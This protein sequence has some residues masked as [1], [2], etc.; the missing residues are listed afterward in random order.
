MIPHIRPKEFQ[1]DFDSFSNHPSFADID[2]RERGKG[3]AIRCERLLDLNDVSLTTIQVC[4]ILGAIGVVDGKP[5][6]E[7]IYYSIACRIAQL[8]NLPNCYAANRV[9]QEVHTRGSC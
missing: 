5:A 2:P 9:E 6:S 7:A 8:L 3:Y 4:V 1:T